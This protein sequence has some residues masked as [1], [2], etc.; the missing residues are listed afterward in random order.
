[1]RGPASSRLINDSYNA[2]PDSLEAGIK[3]VC[4][5]PGSAWLAL[6]D[7]GELGSE[8]ESL[9]RVAAQTAAKYGIERFFGVGEMSCIASE[10]FGEGGH[11]FDNID[12]MS[13]SILAHINAEVNLLVKGSRSAGMERLVAMLTTGDIGDNRGGRNSNAV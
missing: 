6:G 3:V 5:L 1:M 4:S 11:C 8:A 7:M 10:E 2:N 13:A 12:E 9:H